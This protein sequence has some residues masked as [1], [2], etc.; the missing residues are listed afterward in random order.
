MSGLDVIRAIKADGDLSPVPI[1][2]LSASSNNSDIQE[3]IRLGISR[4]VRKASLSW[5]DLLHVIEEIMQ[6]ST[7]RSCYSRSQFA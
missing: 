5:Q 1:I 3:A 2:L 7:G 4:F 6:I